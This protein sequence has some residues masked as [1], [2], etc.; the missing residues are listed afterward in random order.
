MARDILSVL[1]AGASPG[2]G[3]PDET[4]DGE[5]DETAASEDGADGAVD[6]RPPADDG[7]GDEAAESPQ[8][9]GADAPP[10]DPERPERPDESETTTMSDAKHSA[11]DE[12]AESSVDG[13]RLDRAIAAVGFDADEVNR[14]ETDGD[15][16]D[17]ELGI[18]AVD[19]ERA[20]PG[21]LSD[22]VLSKQARTVSKV[23]TRSVDQDRASRVASVARQQAA[24]DVP[25]S[26][27]VATY[28]EAMERV[29]EQ[30]FDDLADG[31]DPETVRADLTA[32][33]KATLVDVQVGVDEFADGDVAPLAE[34]EY[35]E[36]MTFE[37]V[38]DAIPYPVFLIDDEHTLLEYNEGVNR[39]VG[40]EDGHREF[41]GGDN[42]ETI[43][44]ATYTD[45]SRH[46]S[47]VDKVVMNPR[48][49]EDHWDVERVD[50]DNEY[51]D[52]IV[53]EDRSVSTNKAGEETHISFLAVPFF[54][55]DGGL[56]GVFEFVQD[57]S[58]EVLHQ[59][60]VTELVREV[61]STL[62][63]IGDGDLSARAEFDDE[64][65]VV[66]DELLELTVDVNEMADNFQDLI[67]DVDEKTGDLADSIERA[68]TS[69]HNINQ[70]VTDQHSSLE[71][72]ANEMEDFSATME[73][74]A[75]SS[76]EV[77]SAAELALEEADDGVESG[78]DARDVTVEVME[79]SDRLV[80]TVEQLDDYMN[81]IG[82]VVEV[83]SEVADQTNMLA[84]NANIEAARAGEAG[85]GFAVVADEVKTLANETQQHTEE[86]AD[87]IETIQGQTS[88]TV[89]EVEESHDRIQEAESEIKNA[90]G[91]LQTI[92]EKVGTAAH[93]IHEVANANDE[94]AATVEEVM[95]TVDDVREDAKEVSSMTEDIVH[96]AEEQESHV[97]ELSSQVQEL[98]TTTEGDHDHH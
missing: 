53:Y 50:A 83:I 68:T 22:D 87:R 42:R 30:A 14:L 4:E 96:E 77:A 9:T 65:D 33:L 95:A 80:D 13:N 24:S 38:F 39:L 94:Q 32:A 28:G 89:D 31:A 8:D 78:Q 85:S 62:H 48:D 59:K 40:N 25:P 75:A 91:S 60:T 18:R 15:D 81:E 63:A 43:A 29:T 12:R 79:I 69:A 70:K 52:H 44:A 58:Q 76:S 49:A 11:D 93:G 37:E 3:G 7:S 61:T 64:H 16:G 54:D 27:F 45:G 57:R 92:S 41:L 66:E 34:D 74:V 23:A 84:L 35:I 51:T 26:A 55:E 46:N 10:A 36:E 20:Y 21:G 17:A 67:R 6:G 19:I 71:E 73:E 97:F 56:K 90:V 47:L 1:L 2:A 86:I 88:E 82:E 5:R 72:V 98:S